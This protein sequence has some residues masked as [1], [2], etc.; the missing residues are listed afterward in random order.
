MPQRTMDEGPPLRKWNQGLIKKHL[1]SQG[2]SLK[3]QDFRI[4]TVLALCFPHFTFHFQ[5][6]SI[7]CD[8][9]ASVQPGYKLCLEGK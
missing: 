8:D 7:Y 6:G 1:H 9:S 5:N 2:R 3:G 4:A